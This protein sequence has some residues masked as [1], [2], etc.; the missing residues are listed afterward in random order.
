LL[1]NAIVRNG[2]KV[3]TNHLQMGFNSVRNMAP[4]TYD[5]DAANAQWVN[6]QIAGALNTFAPIHNNLSGLQGGQTGQM[7]HV[8]AAEQAFLANV[9]NSGL[10]I[11]STTGSGLLE[12]ADTTEVGATTS[13]AHAL[14]PSN[15]SAVLITTGA[16]TEMHKAISRGARV[17]LIVVRITTATFT[18]PG[19]GADLSWNQVDYDADGLCGFATEGSKSPFTTITVP[20]TG[21][22]EVKAYLRYD[23]NGGGSPFNCTWAVYNTTASTNYGVFIEPVILNGMSGAETGTQIIRVTNTTHSFSLRCMFTGSTPTMRSGTTWTLK[24]IRP[25]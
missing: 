16:P 11:A 5:F 6:G 7:Y 19:T 22:Y 8:T 1:T 25:I 9:V 2:S 23:V 3:M 21:Y 24:W 18:Q 13:N 12:I 4:P 20:W 14:T 15:L 17:P 10:P